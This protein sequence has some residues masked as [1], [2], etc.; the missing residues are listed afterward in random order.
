[1]QLNTFFT[2]DEIQRGVLSLGSYSW[3]LVFGTTNSSI[4][5]FNGSPYANLWLGAQ[6]LAYLT[7]K[8]N[9]SERDAAGAYV[10]SGSG[11]ENRKNQYD[12]F[13]TQFNVFFLCYRKKVGGK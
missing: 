1:M 3:E 4:Q 6:K 9:G 7:N 5:N 12:N 10:G 13:A 8:K 11:A 2:S